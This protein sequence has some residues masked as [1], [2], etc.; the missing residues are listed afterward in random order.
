[1]KM[2]YSNNCLIGNN[3]SNMLMFRWRPNQNT[4][5]NYFYIKVLI[6]HEKL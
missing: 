4:I 2:Y 6:M 1:M 3:S 5:E